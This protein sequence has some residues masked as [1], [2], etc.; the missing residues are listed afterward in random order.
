ME[1][2][3]AGLSAA[4]QRAYAADIADI[5]AWCE[6]RNLGGVASLSARQVF[7]YLV[8][9]RRVG[10]SDAT[11]R[12]RI[13]TLRRIA[14]THLLELPASDLARLEQRVLDAQRGQASVLVV[15]DDPIIRA[16][17]RSVLTESGAV[18]WADA[19]DQLDAATATS[20]D[21]IL[22]WLN[23]P[24]GVDPYGAIVRIGALGSAVTTKVPVVAVHAGA[25]IPSI[26]HLRLA[27]AGAR[28]AVAHSWLSANLT[29]LAA[30]LAGAAVPLKFHLGTPLALRQNLGLRLGGELEPLLGAAVQSPAAVW[31]GHLPQSH[32]PISRSEITRLRRIA[33]DQAGIPAPDFSKYATSPR[34]APATPEWPRVRAV[35][36][37]AFGI[38][39]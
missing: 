16:G 14:S 38:G 25:T 18:C 28:Y 26:V 30:M 31:T 1:K 39:Q 17:L 7:A 23:S 15:S 13:T 10:R 21:Y 4:T 11:L 32:L 35:V 3:L 19:T 33:L 36:R 34:K 5:Q 2:V 20:W 37:E 9:T 8:D 6:D 24:R 29:A 22:V 12:R 27:E